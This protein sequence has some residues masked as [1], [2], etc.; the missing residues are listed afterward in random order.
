MQFW[1]PSSHILIKLETTNKNITLAFKKQAYT[2]ERFTDVSWLEEFTFPKENSYF[3]FFFFKGY[4]QFP[5][6]PFLLANGT[7]LNIH[8]DHASLLA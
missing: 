7:V 5:N 8:L 6:L 3:F 2:L 4:S 1:L